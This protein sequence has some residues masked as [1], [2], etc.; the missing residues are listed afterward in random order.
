MPIRYSHITNITIRNLRTSR[1]LLALSYVYPHQFLP[2]LQLVDAKRQTLSPTPTTRNLLPSLRRRGRAYAAARTGTSSH[3]VPILTTAQRTHSSLDTTDLAQTCRSCR[4]P[5][6]AGLEDLDSIVRGC[7]CLLDVHA[8]DRVDIEICRCSRKPVLLT[9][10]I[11]SITCLCI[12]RR[13][14]IT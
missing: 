9:D 8:L 4:Y 3:S 7:C 5:K 6:P 12:L 1:T 10:F 2:D 14:A 13:R 11:L